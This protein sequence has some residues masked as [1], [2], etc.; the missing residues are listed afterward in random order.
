MGKEDKLVKQHYYVTS[1]QIRS[2]ISCVLSCS[3]VYCIF[4]LSNVIQGIEHGSVWDM[5]GKQKWGWDN[6]IRGEMGNYQPTWMTC[7]GVS[8]CMVAYEWHGTYDNVHVLFQ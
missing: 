6:A 7:D 5:G 3:L 8:Y 4:G 1:S 2:H